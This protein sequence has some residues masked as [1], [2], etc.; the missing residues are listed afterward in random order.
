[1]IKTIAVVGRDEDAW[2][3]ALML[4]LSLGKSVQPVEVTLVELPSNVGA[5]DF[6]ATIPSQ[7]AF[8]ELLGLSEGNVL[9]AG[10][11]VQ[12]LGY[13]YSGWTG[14][15][16]AF[17]HVYD[18][19][20]TSLDGIDFLQ[21]WT[22]ARHR[23]L[24]VALDE[25]SL[26]AAA[27]RR[28]KMIMLNDQTSA[29]SHANHGYNLSA[30]SYL[31]GIAKVALAAGVKHIVAEVERIR[32]KEERIESVLLKG[33]Q[34]LEADLFI[35]ASGDGELIS[36]LNEGF[37]RWDQWFLCDRAI[38]A[39]AER[40][41]PV[42]SFN[43]LSAVHA[44]WL[45]LYPLASRTGVTMQFC[46]RH[47][48]NDEALGVMN[49]A[50][51]QPVQEPKLLA[52]EVGVRTKPWVGNCIAVGNTAARMDGLEGVQLHVLHTA[53]SYLLTLLPVTADY[54]LERNTYNTRLSGHIERLRDFQLAHYSLNGRHSDPFWRAC[55]AVELPEALKEKIELFKARGVIAMSESETF[56]EES[57]N[58]LLTGCGIVPDSYD[59]LVDKIPED[60][61]IQQ[62]QRML[63]FVAERAEQMPDMETFVQVHDA[64]SYSKGL[65]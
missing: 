30:L 29:Y 7:R 21:F 55:A 20:G 26:A 46:S 24:N 11:G 58:A 42:A 18:T 56:Q 14:D 34:S 59:P 27:A 35:D 63:S 41:R 54:D 62:F 4:Q 10:R 39:S 12:S 13:R 45:G 16:S 23:G 17:F 8:H 36:Q 3:T 57:W 64:G 37:R 65:F 50:V 40:L 2:L 25:F 53:L 49:A 31:K 44:G 32:V 38:V 61:Q 60:H 15:S 47:I 5:Q 52:L 19:A 9:S 33:G 28:G 1:M 43:Q 6:Y 22:K 51:G 48:N